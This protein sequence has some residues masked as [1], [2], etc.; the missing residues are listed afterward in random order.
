MNIA[1][2][3]YGS[4]GKRHEKNCLKLGHVVE[5]QSGHDGRQLS[6]NN[7][8]L[9]IISSKTSDH[10]DDVKRFKDLS[11]NFLIEK[12]LAA[13]FSDALKIKKLLHGKNVRVGY[14]LIFNPIIKRVRT[15]IDKNILG[16]VYLGQFY[17]GS[18]L[19][20]WR[21]GDY[22]KSY[23][24]KKSAGGGVE[25]DFIHE[26]NYFQYFFG[27]KLTDVYSFKKKISDLEIDSN[28]FAFF[29]I[30]QDGRFSTITLNCFQK[31]PQRYIR[32]IG[33]KGTL[34]AD[35]INKKVE[36]INAKGTK[37]YSR[38]FAFDYNQMYIDEIISMIKFI[39]NNDVQRKILGLDQGIKDLELL[40]EKS[41]FK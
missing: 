3:G 9:V 23:S 11:N 29:A 34:F 7:Y 24:A 41:I 8:D 33:K 28:D 30:K 31:P 27:E 40:K 17:A 32:L 26:L 18:Y 15:I 1:I 25:L 13:N 21:E 14:C 12:P 20:D 2:V 39:K 16:E 10:I 5:V 37:I 36:V 22:R 19:P 6:R 4:I 38:R 35:I